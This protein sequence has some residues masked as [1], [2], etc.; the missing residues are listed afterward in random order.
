MFCSVETNFTFINVYYFT[1]YLDIEILF[2]LSHFP[3]L[4]SLIVLHCSVAQACPTLYNPM[5]CSPPGSSAHG[6]F[7]AR[8]LQ[9]GAISYSRESSW[10]RDQTWVSCISC[11]SRRVFTA[12]LPG[13]SYLS[14]FPVLFPLSTGFIVKH[15]SCH[16]YLLLFQYS[17]FSLSQCG[18]F[19]LMS[20]L[21]SVFK[22]ISHVITNEPVK[23][24]LYLACILSLLFIFLILLVT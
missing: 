22:L 1:V 9:W 21:Q 19:I 14:Y 24:H 12:G 3:I 15:Q 10:L 4:F 8:T 13:M 6:I 16:Q 20:T 7:Q 11:L 17:E 5:D 2:Y 18:K 23:I